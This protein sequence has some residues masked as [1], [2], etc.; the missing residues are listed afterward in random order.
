MIAIFKR[1]VKNYLKRPLFWIGIALVIYGVFDA[2][3]PYLTTHYLAPGEKIVNDYPDTIHLAEVYEGYIPASPGKHRELWHERIKESLLEDGEMSDSEVQEVIEK[4][5]DM[6]LEEAYAYLE[7]EYDWY[8]ARY[9]YED[10][11]YYK[12]SPEEINAY[13]IKNWKQRLF[14]FTIPGSLLILPVCLWDFLQQSCCLFC[15]CRIRENI[16]MNCSTQNQFL[17]ESMSWEK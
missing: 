17:P 1:E 13:L 5:E 10:T 2:T 11:T 12:G 6:D 14:L 15:F 4:L 8:G 9:L 16:L 3:S 7:K